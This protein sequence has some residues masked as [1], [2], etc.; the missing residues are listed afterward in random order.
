MFSEG[1]K[2]DQWHEMGY[3]RKTLCVIV[4][5]D[6]APCYLVRISTHF[7]RLPCP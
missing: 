6:R 7:D 5:I 2:R 4:R 3:L 1:I